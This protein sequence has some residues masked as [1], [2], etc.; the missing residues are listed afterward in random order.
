MALRASKEDLEEVR[1]CIRQGLDTLDAKDALK[2][3]ERCLPTE[4]EMAHVEYARERLGNWMRS[5][6]ACGMVH[7]GPKKEWY[8]REFAMR[9][10]EEK[11][12]RKKK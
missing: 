5:E 4:E 12:G 9:E 10:A 1:R 8:E 6:E 2:V 7:S 11:E 3:F